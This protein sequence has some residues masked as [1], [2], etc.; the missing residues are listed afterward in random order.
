M[1]SVATSDARLYKHLAWTHSRLGL[2]VGMND[3]EA[4]LRGLP[5]LVLRYEAQDAACRRVAAW[6]QSQAAFVRVLHPALPDSPGHVHWAELCRAAAG[7]VT[8]EFDPRYSPQQVDGFV[9]A[10][11][12]FRIGWSWG[13]PVSLAVPYHAHEMRSLPTP[14]KGTL[15][16]LCIGLEN[17]DDLIA[18]LAQGLQAL[19]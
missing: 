15:V 5:S 6:C 18:D 17:V 16:R 13:G 3:V 7:L 19:V 12:L 1:G 8:V 4:V 14:Y 2:G 9:D 11:K 10:L